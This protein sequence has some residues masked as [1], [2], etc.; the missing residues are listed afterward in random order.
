MLRVTYRDSLSPALQARIDALAPA[1]RTEFLTRAGK[2]SEQLLKRHFRAREATGKNKQ[3]WPR[4]HF[5]ARIG[6]ATAFV[7]ANPSSA[8]VTIADP[9]INQKIHGGSIEAPPGKF[10]A[11][12]LRAKAYGKKPSSGLIENLFIIRSRVTKKLFLARKEGR[13]LVLYYILVKRTKPQAPDRDALP[14]MTAF[15]EEV[16]QAAVNHISGS[17]A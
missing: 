6:R 12:P 5:W 3:G 1:G 16:R 14:P 13:K 10:L 4:Q 17:K 11:I 2:R 15:N 9:A 8:M 7:G